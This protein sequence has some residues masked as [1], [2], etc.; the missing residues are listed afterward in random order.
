MERSLNK[1]PHGDGD[2]DG[3]SGLG[4]ELGWWSWWSYASFFLCNIYMYVHLPFWK[5][6]R[7]VAQGRPPGQEDLLTE[8]HPERI[9]IRHHWS[10]H[11]TRSEGRET[12]NHGSAAAPFPAGAQPRRTAGLICT[13]SA[14][15]RL[16]WVRLQ[17]F[18]WCPIRIPG[19]ARSFVRW[20]EC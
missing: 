11:Q 20:T 6:S 9:P 18:R 5:G 10:I 19:L 2:G 13:R 15:L 8:L 14:S 17:P 1:L 12:I 3:D 4:L 16:S 7:F